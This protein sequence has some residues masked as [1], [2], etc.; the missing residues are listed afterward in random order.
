M[1]SGV[2]QLVVFHIQN[3]DGLVVCLHKMKPAGD[4]RVGELVGVL[5]DH[6]RRWVRMTGYGGHRQW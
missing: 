1:T 4:N 5:V 2:D 3:H 6:F